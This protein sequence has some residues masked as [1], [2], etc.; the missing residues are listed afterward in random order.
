MT[1][2]HL[3]LVTS[4]LAFVVRPALA[5]L[6]GG[7]TLYPT[8]DT[9]AS[10]TLG[11]VYQLIF[12]WCFI[13]GYM[14]VR[15]QAKKKDL[16]AVTTSTSRGWCLSLL[17]GVATL[18]VIHTLS[19]GVWLPTAR[20]RTITSAVPFGKVLFPLAVIPLSMG[21]PLG[22]LV[23]L[24]KRMLRP[25]VTIAVAGAILL[26]SLL[27]QRGFVISGLVV[28]ILLAEKIGEV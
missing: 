27:Y 10:Y 28:A 11:L 20:F 14:L 19:G 12:N 13:I 18:G 8:G 6:A 7:Y 4:A 25:I 26:L 15:P 16:P 5:L 24:G 3:F 23:A 9:W 21:L 2:F 1:L 22:Y 17:V